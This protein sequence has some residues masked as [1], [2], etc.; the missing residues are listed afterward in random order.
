M[1]GFFS[2]SLKKPKTSLSKRPNYPGFLRWKQSSLNFFIS[3][4]ASL[5]TT[6]AETATTTY[7]RFRPVHCAAA[8]FMNTSAV[9][10]G[11]SS[12]KGV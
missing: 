2:S 9:S 1:F 10:Q 4:I 12:W 11:H 5:Q 6:G 7:E 3:L 8:Q